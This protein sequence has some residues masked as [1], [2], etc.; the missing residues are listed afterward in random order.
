VG[1]DVPNNTTLYTFWCEHKGDWQG[2]RVRTFAWRQL[3]IIQ[4][5][6]GIKFM[7]LT[8]SVLFSNEGSAGT[9]GRGGRGDMRVEEWDCRPATLTKAFHE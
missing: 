5:E 9:T 6:M 3:R 1:L 8:T 4:R 7:N 2:T